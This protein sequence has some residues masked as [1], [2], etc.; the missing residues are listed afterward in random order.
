MYFIFIYSRWLQ[1]CP[2]YAHIAR[3]IVSIRVEDEI[4]TFSR[5]QNTTCHSA[6]HCHSIDGPRLFQVESQYVNSEKE[7]LIQNKCRTHCLRLSLLAH[8]LYW[9]CLTIYTFTVTEINKYLEH[10]ERF[11]AIKL[12]HSMVLNKNI[13]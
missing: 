6:N 10:S 3:H 7:T 12:F 13:L 4:V 5:P 1:E 9:T 11:N 8:Q 2:E